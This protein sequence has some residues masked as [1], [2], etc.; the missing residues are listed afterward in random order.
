MT[1]PCEV[2][3]VDHPKAR[4]IHRCDEC[5]GYI[6]RGEK[7]SNQHGVFDGQGFTHK[8][9]CDCSALI[10]VLNEGKHEDE[11]VSFGDLGEFA[12]ES[13]LSEYKRFIAIKQKRGA[14]VSEH[15][16][17]TLAEWEDEKK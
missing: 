15:T 5:L 16:L 17:K 4:K 6:Q 11:I 13:G 12:Y 1:E 2:F 3:V 10:N 9:C 8:V 7:Y 14:V